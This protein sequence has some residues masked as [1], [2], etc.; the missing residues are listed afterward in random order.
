MNTTWHVRQLYFCAAIALFV[1]TQ[2][3]CAGSSTP[4]SSKKPT[5]ETDTTPQKSPPR[6][7]TIVAVSEEEMR[8]GDNL[9]RAVAGFQQQLEFQFSTLQ[10]EFNN[11]YL[12]ELK[13]DPDLMGDVTVEFTVRKGGAL[14]QEGP[15]ISHSTLGNERVESCILD[16]VRKQTYPE[17]HNGN[18]TDVARTLHFGEF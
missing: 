7:S 12:P 15:R 14:D 9:E 10:K 3:A 1:L 8:E 11:C 17:P 16:L 4:T 5:A 2:T 13:R 18:F 6:R